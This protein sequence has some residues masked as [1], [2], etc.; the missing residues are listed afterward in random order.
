MY[1]IGGYFLMVSI[2]CGVLGS[3]AAFD[4]F[5]YIGVAFLCAGFLVEVLK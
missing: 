1:Y 5:M 2:F 4:L 3:R